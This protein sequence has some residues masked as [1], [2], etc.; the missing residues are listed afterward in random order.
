MMPARNA[1]WS[2]ARLTWA[3][4]GLLTVLVTSVVAFTNLQDIY[5]A[6]KDFVVGSLLSIAGFCFGRA[7]NRTDEVI[8]D[9]LHNAGAFQE[10]S[11][12][13]R[14]VDAAVERLSE[15][16]DAQCQ[17]L[18][19]HRHSPL[20]R[21]ALDDLNKTTANVIKLR[22][23]LGDS[24]ET[25]GY[26]L[27]SA[28][29]LALISARRDLNEAINRRN[30]VYEW[31]APQLDP[32]SETATWDIFAVMSSDLIKGTRTLEA[33]LTQHVSGSPEERLP[34]I[35]G[36]LTMAIKRAEEFT[37]AMP[38]TNISI[39]KVFDVMVGDIAKA[40]DVIDRVELGMSPSARSSQP[41]AGNAG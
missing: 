19:F 22:S 24:S 41:V 4:A 23:D 34:P 17:Q 20:L 33:L 31:L 25:E 15:Y 6:Q 30:Q 8:S 16:Y 37:E 32:R 11:R 28:A 13:E 35:R 21:V 14:N 5:N 29:R 1:P 36:Y 12:L 18:D 7:L 26:K 27:P 38:H 40:L 9:H 10:L 3:T 2:S 39:P